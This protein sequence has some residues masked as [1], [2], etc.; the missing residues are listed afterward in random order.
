MSKV[1]SDNIT[2]RADDGAPKLVFGAEVPVG[3]GITGAGGINITGVATAASFSG[4][5]TGNVTG[6]ATGLSG[7]PNIT[8]NNLTGVAAT[9]TGV[10]TYEDVTNVDSI[11]IITA[12]SGVSIADS[13][14]HTGDDNTA[15]RFPAADTFTVETAGSERVRIASGGAAIFKGGLAEKYE[16]A[17]TTL[18]AQTDNPLSDGNVILFTGNESGNTT[19]NFTGVH[20]TLSNGETVSFTAIITPNNSGVIN[21]VQIDGQSP[22]GGLKWSGGSAPTAGSSGQDIYTFQILKT[23]TG[24]TNYT[25]YGAAANYA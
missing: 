1:R 23:G 3:Y 24:A 22:A 2:N 5:L 17:G 21:A 9:F 13:I 15:I 10:L 7:S 4:N 11:G 25:V 16:N 18:G 19:I 12:R 8:I 6:T 14:F 20:A